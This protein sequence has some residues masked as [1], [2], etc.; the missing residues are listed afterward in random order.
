M[1]K[2]RFYS[3]IK[4]ELMVK[5]PEV[6][7]Q[8]FERGEKTQENDEQKQ[9]IQTKRDHKEATKLWKSD[10]NC[11]RLDFLVKKEKV[12]E[13]LVKNVI[14]KIEEVEGESGKK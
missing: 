11:E 8:I 6:Y 7:Q 1:V 9:E 12:L 13:G 2:N 5:Q 4:R 3:A 14:K 10:E